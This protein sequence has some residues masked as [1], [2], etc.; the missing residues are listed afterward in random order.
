M[1]QIDKECYVQRHGLN[2]AD[3][4]SLLIFFSEVNYTDK[5]LWLISKPWFLFY[6]AGIS[7][8]MH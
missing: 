1:W 3:D 8:M 7:L 4:C 2:P 5:Y 6:R